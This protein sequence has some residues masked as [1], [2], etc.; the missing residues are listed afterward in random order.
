VFELSSFD[1]VSSSVVSLLVRLFLLSEASLVE[2]S[3]VLSLVLAV[4]PCEFE[5]VLFP[6]Q[7]FDLMDEFA[8][9]NMR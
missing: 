8:P 5:F 6:T 4:S 9:K 1:R 2:L 7:H 3:S